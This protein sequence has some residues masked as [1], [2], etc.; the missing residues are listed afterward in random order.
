MSE[1]GF[2]SKCTRCSAPF[3]HPFDFVRHVFMHGRAGDQT[4]IGAEAPGPTILDILR[5][6]RREKLH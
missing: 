6:S 5:E 3:Y 2:E 1:S 4:C